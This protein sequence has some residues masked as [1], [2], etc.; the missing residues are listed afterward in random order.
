MQTIQVKL[1]P[2]YEDGIPRI[3]GRLIYANQV[4]TL[5]LEISGVQKE[6]DFYVNKGAIEVIGEQPKAETQTPKATP[7]ENT[8]AVSQPPKE[9]QTSQEPPVSPTPPDAEADNPPADANP[10]TPQN[11][12]KPDKKGNGK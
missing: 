12:A 8:P 3:G 7:P 6:L 4:H 1:K 11:P 10:Q 5:N 2:K 9:G